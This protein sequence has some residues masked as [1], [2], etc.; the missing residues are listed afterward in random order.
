MNRTPH[1]FRIARWSVIL[2]AAFPLMLA[3]QDGPRYPWRFDRGD[4]DATSR[5]F[6]GWGMR[7]MMEAAGLRMNR[8][9]D[10]SASADPTDQQWHD[11]SEY[12]KR[13]LPNAWRAYSRQ[14]TANQAQMRR[15]IFSQFR[16]TQMLRQTNQIELYTLKLKERKLMDN[17]AGLVRQWRKAPLD[18]KP[19]IRQQLRDTMKQVMLA[20]LQERELRIKHLEQQLADEK[21]KV[22]QDRDHL[23]TA[24]DRRVGHMLDLNHAQQ[25]E[26][27]DDVT[28]PTTQPMVR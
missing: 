18:Q 2:L 6:I 1:H 28:A 24:L 23:D 4:R 14:S 20:T 8:F 26:E 11:I 9:D 21:E 22:T 16:A 7:G 5:P 25:V 10:E 15:Q 13:E 17:A 19:A 27:A 3:A 12:M